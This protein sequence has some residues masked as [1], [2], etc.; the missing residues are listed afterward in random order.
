MAL[1]A[2]E[3]A[4]QQRIVS[5][6]DVD[7]A[8]ALGTGLRFQSVD[9]HGCAE[10]CPEEAEQIARIYSDLLRCGWVNDKGEEKLLTSDD[11]LVVSPYNMQFDLLRSVLPD[12]ARVGTLDKFQG[13][14]GAVLISMATSS[15]DFLGR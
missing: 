9:H 4:K 2:T 14:E 15:G 12:G 13:Q 1:E 10:K 6:P 5:A 8:L 11:V 7:P 3:A